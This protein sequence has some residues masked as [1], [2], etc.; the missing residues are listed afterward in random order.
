M[1]RLPRCAPALHVTRR[2]MLA[3]LAGTVLG[4]SLPARAA[5]RPLRIIGKTISQTIKG[6]AKF[7]RFSVRIAVAWAGVAFD[8]VL[9][10][11]EV[12]VGKV[13]NWTYQ[14]SGLTVKLRIAVAAAAATITVQLLGPAGS[15][16]EQQSLPITAYLQSHVDHA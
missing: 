8:Q 10:T 6:S 1:S 15:I 7:V 13:A 14:M 5:P 4:S 11:F 16:S 9:G 3:L 12:A 2:S